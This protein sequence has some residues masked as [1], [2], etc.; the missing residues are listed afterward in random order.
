ME[1]DGASNTSVDDI[2]TLRESVKFAPSAGKFKI[3]IIDEVHMLSTAA[4]NALLK[5][6][7]E[8]PEFVKFIFA[9]T[10]PDKIP[11][12]VL[13][14]CQRLDFRRI[15]VMEIIAQ[16]EKIVAQEQIAVDKEVLFAIAKSSDGALRDAESILDQLVSFSKGQVCL[17]DVV[18]ML[19]MVAQEALFE[20]T[21]TFIAKDAK[22]ALVLLNRL[23]DE[24]KDLTAFLV[25]LIEHFR[26]LM[27]AKVSKGDAELLDLPSEICGRL[28]TQSQ[29]FSLDELFCNFTMLANTRE[30]TKRLD[31]LRIPLEI[32]L[33]RLAHD[34]RGNNSAITQGKS[35]SQVSH[36]A[37]TTREPSVHSPEKKVQTH[38][39]E[40]KDIPHKTA[41]GPTQEHRAISFEQ[42]TDGWQ[43][44]ITTLEK[45]KMS[46][47]TYLNEGKLM[48]VK[49]DIL[50]ISFP[51]NYSHHKESL[52]RKENRALIEKCIVDLLHFD[53]RVNFVLSAEQKKHVEDLRANPFVKSALDMFGGRLLN[54]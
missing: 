37:E 29:E 34:K 15:A 47:A 31:S 51:Q 42:I 4:F 1:I 39:C 3:Y 30:M 13:S 11:S 52:E 53:L 54:E 7:E 45:I 43:H 40:E 41:Q 32:A 17:N 35:Q 16:L 8:P 18:S 50:T 12:T 19:G 36:S 14:R 5:T 10:H 22:R 24:G 9:T 6:L 26:N 33:V 25:N 48:G 38:A 46:V 28:L 23:I 2:R 27:I 21:D 20:I 44:I 49:G